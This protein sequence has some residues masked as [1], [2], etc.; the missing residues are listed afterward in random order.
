MKKFI[1]ITLTAIMAFACFSFFPACF[2]THTMEHVE[3]KVATCVA[4]GIAEHYYC[5]G[6][7]KYFEDEEGKVKITQEDTILAIDST[8]HNFTYSPIYGNDDNHNCICQDCEHVETAAHKFEPIGKE[9]VGHIYKGECAC[10]VKTPFMTLPVIRINADDNKEILGSRTGAKDYSDCKITVT[11]EEQPEYNM[12]DVVAK[13]KV[14]GNYTAD[15]V[16][17]PWRIKF[18]KKQVMLGLDGENK[19]KN[20]VLLADWKDG[21]K[22]RNAT[23][24]YLGNEILETDGYYCTDYRHVEVYLNG[25]YRG[26]YLL[27]DQQESGGERIDIP[28]DSEYK[29]NDMGYIVEL[30]AYA[31][32]E[33]AG[34]WF[35]MTYKNASGNQIERLKWLDGSDSGCGVGRFE[36]LYAIKSDLYEDESET[37]NKTEEKQIIDAQNAFIKKRIENTFSVVYDSIYGDHA[38]LSTNPYLTLDAQGNIIT[39]STI[40]T[41][42][43]AVERVVDLQSLVDTYILNEICVDIDVGWS[44]F[45]M[46]VDLSAEGNKLLTFQAPW[47]WDYALGQSYTTYN[48]HHST[49]P[50]SG[51]TAS[52]HVNPW[53]VICC[54]Q[55]WFWD[56]VQEKWDDL[57]ERGVFDEAIARIR[58]HGEIYADYRLKDKNI[59]WSP[60]RAMNNGSTSDK[61]DATPE[62][63]NS[64]ATWLTNRINWLKTNIPK[65]K[66]DYLG[67]NS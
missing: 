57:V 51:T 29:G 46:S 27:C 24:F 4:T 47:D 39:G 40:A 11:S 62:Q 9:N 34:Y 41:S 36:Q 48:K 28:D 67:I 66:S 45:R 2:H 60:I 64:F 56:E 20:W 16:K 25:S 15:Y 6:C 13:V 49:M 26:L 43:Q 21:A 30:D 61:R 12:T 65:V 55:G 18:D 10:T 35:Q 8:N 32:G 31:Q 3:G 5:E 42:R 53:L 44:S 50:T 7:G 37:P 19:A 52:T 38:D 63:I 14:R 23:A 17:K 58:L 22:M 1:T 33:D 54:R 59:D